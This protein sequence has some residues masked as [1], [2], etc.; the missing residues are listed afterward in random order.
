MARTQTRKSTAAPQPD[1][2]DHDQRIRELAYRLWEADGKMH[3]R[4]LEYWHR[5]R[6]LI[7]SEDSIEN[8]IPKPL[9]APKRRPRAK[10]KPPI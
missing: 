9:R 7:G 8:S 6:D 5:A 10:P 2:A 3:G 1:V 4:D